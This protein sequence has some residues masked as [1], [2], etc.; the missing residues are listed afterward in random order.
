MAIIIEILYKSGIYKITHPFDETKFYIGSANCF[1]NRW[2]Q[3]YNK[4]LTNA[5]QKYGKN[6]FHFEI[7]ELVEDFSGNKLIHKSVLLQREQYWI[8]ILKHYYNVSLTA[9]SPLGCKRSLESKKKMSEARKG[10]YSGKN[11]PL[12]GTH[13]SKEVKDKIS[14]GN[15]GKY[16]TEE[17]KIKISK[18]LKGKMKGEKNSMYGTKHTEEWKIK[19]KELLK[20]ENSSM[21][22]L[23]WNKVRE[24]REKFLTGFYTRKMLSEEYEV[25]LSTICRIIKNKTWKEE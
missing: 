3:K 2:Y 16:H 8:N 19:M 24:L 23:T 15:K 22:K 17:S 11:H 9:G 7:I 10:K 21:A 13:R 4:H 6:N 25:E 12:Y 18:A 5:F 1:I 14:L 20:G